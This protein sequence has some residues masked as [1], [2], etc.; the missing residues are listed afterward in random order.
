M[1][2]QNFLPRPAASLQRH[3]YVHARLLNFMDSS[4]S[5]PKCEEHLSV[6]NH[7]EY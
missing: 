2:K 7:N 6:E 3:A 5:A 1:H 4:Q